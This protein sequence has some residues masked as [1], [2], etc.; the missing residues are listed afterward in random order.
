M[1]AVAAALVPGEKKIETLQKIVAIF[2]FWMSSVAIG[3]EIVVLAEL[4][5]S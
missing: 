4:N 2:L 1:A 5:G 3:V